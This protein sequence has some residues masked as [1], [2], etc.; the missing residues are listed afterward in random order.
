MILSGKECA[1]QPDR[2]PDLGLIPL[3]V[4][5][6]GHRDVSSEYAD[7]IEECI[8]KRLRRF[9]E[10]HPDSPLI[11]LSA[12]A[13]GADQMVAKVALKLG[14]S[15]GVILPFDQAEVEQDFAEPSELHAFRSLLAQAAFVQTVRATPVHAQLWA[16]DLRTAGFRLAGIRMLQ[17]SQV[18]LALWDGV[19]PN[20][21][22]G[23]TDVV[24]MFRNGIPCVDGD[25]GAEL[26]LPDTGPVWHVVTPRT[27]T[28]GLCGDAVP[29]SLVE[30]SPSPAGLE[31]VGESQRW[32]KI[33]GGIDRFNADAR[34]ALSDQ[35]Q[36]VA[37]SL[38]YLGD[39]GD[40]LNPAA[41]RAG[42]LHAVADSISIR[43][44][45]T[46]QQ[47]Y[48]GMIGLAVLAFVFEQ[49]YTGPLF[50]PIWAVLTASCAVLALLLSLFIQRKKLEQRYLDYRT[51]AEACRVQYFWKLAGMRD[52][53]SRFFLRGQRDELEWLRQAVNS[54]E[55]CNEPGPQQ[56]QS[57]TEAIRHVKRHWLDDQ[58]KYFV[59]L[60]NVR[61]GDKASFNEREGQRWGRYASSFLL[62]AL[63]V[64]FLVGSIHLM[65]HPVEEGPWFMPLQYAVV[66]YGVL[67][68]LAG[69]ALAYRE[70]KAYEENGRRYRRMGLS[71]RMANQALD[72]ALEKQDLQQAHEVLRAIGREALSENGDWLILHRDRPATVPVS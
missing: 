18:L 52:M 60:P 28:G 63:L 35:P 40:L 27:S 58:Q 50:E 70:T 48:L 29:A 45:K 59:G 32:E 8:D 12:L 72:G 5:V 66:T 53:V 1:D 34:L 44:Q 3:A 21:P 9:G 64:F 4:G 33:L 10:A 47:C 7:A 13:E 49:I 69:V 43:T 56:V 61:G 54:T 23:T 62:G 36:Q 51:L 6:T 38:S 30:L 68:A 24:H 46:R 14:W 20:R 37:Q 65:L 16:V 67:L 15:L 57:A 17:M 22:G 26:A 2:S 41:V 25:V 71:M 55:L 42:Q 31:T 39:A 11:L 19:S